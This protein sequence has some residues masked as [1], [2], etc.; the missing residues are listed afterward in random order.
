[1]CAEPADARHWQ[2]HS[3]QP[4][5]LLSQPCS[6]ALVGLLEVESSLCDMGAL[7]P[8]M[9]KPKS[10][11]VRQEE[12]G[13]MVDKEMA[14]TSAAIEDAVRRIEVKTGM[15]GSPPVPSGAGLGCVPLGRRQS[16]GKTGGQGGR[17]AWLSHPD[18]SGCSRGGGGR[19]GPVPVSPVL[20]HCPPPSLLT[21]LSSGIGHDEPGPPCQLWGETGGE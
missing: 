16:W 14:A 3:T 12:L 5:N 20:P 4:K 18:L 19:P 9:L 17:W 13:A 15:W 11:D 1:M 8:Q 10:L 21:A 2:E 7:L 6:Q